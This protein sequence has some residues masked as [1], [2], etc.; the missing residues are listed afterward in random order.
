MKDR[1]VTGAAPD[2]TGL[3]PEHAGCWDDRACGV[4]RP[5]RDVPRAD[6]AGF[7]EPGW[8]KI[9]CN[10]TVRPYGS[11]RTLLTCECR[12]ATTDPGSG[13]KFARYWWLVRPFAAYIM[14]AAL[15]AI[16]AGAARSRAGQSVV[17]GEGHPDRPPAMP[18]RQL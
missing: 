10:F 7:H 2:R 11:D 17:V 3:V 18:V 5:W 6:F 9:A 1:E 15:A 13:R 16:A 8:G 14:R 12:T 4:E